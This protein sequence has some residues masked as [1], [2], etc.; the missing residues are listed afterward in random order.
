MV[1]GMKAAFISRVGPPEA[2]SVG[3]LP[4][5][6]PGQG[7]V[8]VRVKAASVNPIDTYIRS[9]A[10]PADLTFPYI[11]GSDFAGVVEEVGAGVE[12]V[13]EGDRVWGANRGIAGRQGSFAEWIAA[14]AEW[15]YPTPDGVTDEAM[16]GSAVTGLTAW[17]GLAER[18]GLRAGESI[19]VQGGSGGIGSMVLQMAKAIGARAIA[20]A[21]TP[22][23]LDR[24][25]QLG[26]DVAIGHA[27][28]DLPRQVLEA[29]PGG[30]DVWW[31]TRRSPDFDLILGCLAKFG[32][33]LLMA[34]RDARPAFPVGPFYT[35]CASISG[36]VLFAFPAEK[37]RA[38]A[39]AINGLFSER[40]IGA[41]IDRVMALGEVAEAHRLQWRSTVEGTGELAGKIVI[42]IG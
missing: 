16:A 9:G 36:H 28:E 26:A 18:V 39:E 3:D 33:V 19:L 40:K 4:K 22:E 24:C 34:G 12:N 37:Q 11:V 6:R 15:V 29:A 21:G 42:R 31:E 13:R 35:K 1:S 25:R 30:V 2:L 17:L 41:Q 10:V 5:P 20:T 27:G 8:L 23:K 7:E 14:G 38:A 32:R